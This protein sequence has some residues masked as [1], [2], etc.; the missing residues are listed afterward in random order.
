MSFCWSLWVLGCLTHFL[1]EKS[2]GE[3]IEP[4]MLSPEVKS[5][6]H[7]FLSFLAAESS[8]DT[9]LTKATF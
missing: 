8:V 1:L 6:A 3:E 9:H 4:Q 5:P 7:S 2:Q